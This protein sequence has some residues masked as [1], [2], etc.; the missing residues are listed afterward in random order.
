MKSILLGKTAVWI[1][2][3][4]STV[5]SANMAMA[6]GDHGHSHDHDEATHEEQHDEHQKKNHDKHHDEK[7]TEDHHEDRVTIAPEIAKN[8]GITTALAGEGTL[9]KSRRLYGKIIADP[10]RVSHIR[11]R[12]PGIITQVHASLGSTIKAGQ[13]LLEIEA[14]ESLKRYSITA[15]ISGIIIEKHANVG[16]FSGEQALITLANYEQVWVE[17]NVFSQDAALI[18]PGQTVTMRRDGATTESRI[19]YITPAPGDSPY[20]VARVAVENTKGQ[21]S[22]GAFVESD[23]EIDTINVPVV[24]DSRALQSIRDEQVVFIQQ[25]DTYEVRPLKLGAS[26][27]H[28]TEVLAGLNSGDRYVVKN[29]YILKADL[30]KSGASHDH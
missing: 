29:S 10:Q 6:S 18:R 5:F 30:E 11:A 8:A 2:L 15:P 23:V 3:V 16:E 22:P 24:V 13:P 27:G 14:N 25:G 12:F 19:G 28:H 9:K 1:L 17:L 20:L 21:W 4:L 26:D 7:S